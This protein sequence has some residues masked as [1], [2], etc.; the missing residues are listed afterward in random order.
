MNLLE[1]KQIVDHAVEHSHDLDQITVRILTFKV[2]SAGHVPC[3]D[4]KSMMMGFD[5]EARSFLIQPESTLREI[6]RD[7]IK[8]LRDK[9][10]ELSWSLYRI[11]KI[12]RENK[13]LKEQLEQLK[14]VQNDHP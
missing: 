1:L 2:G 7:E 4:V 6:D 10:E 9:Y 13:Q 11:D 3:T 5:W 12:K 14:K 8:T